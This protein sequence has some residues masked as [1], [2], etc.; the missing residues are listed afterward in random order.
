MRLADTDPAAAG[1]EEVLFD[2]RFGTPP[3][4]TFFRV[5]SDP[6]FTVKAGIVQLN[7]RDDKYFVVPDLWASLGAEKTFGFRQIFTCQTI[8]HETFLWGCRLPGADGKQPPWVTIPLEAAKAAQAKWVR[9]FW[10][11]AQRKHRVLTAAASHAEP[12][13]PDKSLGELLRLAFKDAL[14]DSIDHS[15]LKKLRGEI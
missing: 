6:D 14:I 12:Q 11:D 8:Q 10:D 4:D 15:V 13:W 1:V 9:I 7:G 2:I 3:K 5:N